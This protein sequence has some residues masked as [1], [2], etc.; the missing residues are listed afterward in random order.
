MC[1]RYPD[2][3][4]VRTHGNLGDQGSDGLSL[5]A[6]KL[7]ACYAPRSFDAAKL[8]KKFHDDL[9]SALAQRMGQF[10]TFVFVHNDLR[11]VH[12]EVGTML[13]EAD[14][15]SQG[16]EKI[17]KFSTLLTNLVVF[18]TTL[19]GAGGAVHVRGRCPVWLAGSVV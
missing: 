1:A 10:G 8:R 6:R 17:V 11:G 13:M 15:A 16:R 4:D 9:N 12:P 14:R 19:D 18:H 3:L 2:F 7:Y 5:H